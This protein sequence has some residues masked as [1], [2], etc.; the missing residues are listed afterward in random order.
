MWVEI[1]LEILAVAVNL[2]T[3]PKR[4]EDKIIKKKVRARRK[5]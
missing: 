4:Y 2:S 5:S 1:T 3:S